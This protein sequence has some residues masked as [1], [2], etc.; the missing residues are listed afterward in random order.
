[1][2][3]DDKM[4]K[5]KKQEHDLEFEVRQLKERVEILEKQMKEYKE[6]QLKKLEAELDYAKFRCTL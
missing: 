1:M 6:A 5:E 4:N 3:R 2:S